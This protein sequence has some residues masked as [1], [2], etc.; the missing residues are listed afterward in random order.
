MAACNLIALHIDT[1]NCETN[2]VRFNY[3]RQTI[4]CVMGTMMATLV[5]LFFMPDTKKKHMF[6]QINRLCRRLLGSPV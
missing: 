2:S 5:S 6:V 4:R 1:A 3:L